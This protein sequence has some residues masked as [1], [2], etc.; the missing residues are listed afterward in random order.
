VLDEPLRQINGDVY[1]DRVRGMIE[2][3]AREF[4]IQFIIASNEDWMKI[5][6]VVQL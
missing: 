6:K 5:G 2:S 3:L 4:G 1:R